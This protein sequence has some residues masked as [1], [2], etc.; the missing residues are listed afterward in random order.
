MEN[1]NIYIG[2]DHLNMQRQ[3]NISDES[4]CAGYA[5]YDSKTG[6]VIVE[7]FADWRKALGNNIDP[8]KAIAAALKRD[9]MP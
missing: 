9:L 3:G 6:D 5:R 1:Y 2:S 4:L 7:D 8:K